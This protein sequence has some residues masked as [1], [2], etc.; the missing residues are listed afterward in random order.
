MT[1][2]AFDA[3]IKSALKLTPEKCVQKVQVLVRKVA[4]SKLVDYIVDSKPW[5]TF[6]RK[7]WKDITKGKYDHVFIRQP[8]PKTT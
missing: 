1:R 4:A 3:E 2:K 5:H 8:Q 7:Y 6:N